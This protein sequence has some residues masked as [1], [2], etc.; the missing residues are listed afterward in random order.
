MSL[1]YSES[2]ELNVP[3]LCVISNYIELHDARSHRA[4][5]IN[6]IQFKYQTHKEKIKGA[7]HQGMWKIFADKG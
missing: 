2:N 7:L 5:L 6:L 1:S 4:I 3:I